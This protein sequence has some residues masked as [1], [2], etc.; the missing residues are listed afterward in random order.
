[1]SDRRDPPLSLDALTDILS[2]IV[3]MAIL[4]CL[5]AALQ[6]GT[7][8]EHIAAP[9]APGLAMAG[10]EMIDDAH[11]AHDFTIHSWAGSL[12]KIHL[13]FGPAM[14]LR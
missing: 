1:M 14:T 5:V 4:L 9:I 6:R 2:N 12:R 11:L 10:D 8:V 13:R 7:T 3:G